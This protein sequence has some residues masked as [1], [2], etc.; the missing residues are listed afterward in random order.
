MLLA[1]RE[2]LQKCN[3]RDNTISEHYI[4]QVYA[5][6]ALIQGLGPRDAYEHLTRELDGVQQFK[7]GVEE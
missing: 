5:Q 2:E 7:T 1:T 6:A 4:N 3:F